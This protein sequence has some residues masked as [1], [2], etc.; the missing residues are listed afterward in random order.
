[1]LLTPKRAVTYTSNGWEH[2]KY[3]NDKLTLVR[4]VD[5]AVVQWYSPDDPMNPPS[6]FARLAHAPSSLITCA[7]VHT[8]G[9]CHS[10][11]SLPDS[12]VNMLSARDESERTDKRGSQPCSRSLQGFFVARAKRA[13]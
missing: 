10:S 5:S 8:L 3:T 11:S 12:G 4:K 1:M 9:R 13:I 2:K 7:R 6:R